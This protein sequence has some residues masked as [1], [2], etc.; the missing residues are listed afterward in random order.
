[1]IHH[2][3]CLFG[4]LAANQVSADPIAHTLAEVVVAESADEEHYSQG[5]T[6]AARKPAGLLSTPCSVGVVN[7]VL[8]RD[9]LAYR[10]EDLAPF[11]SGVQASSADSGFNT[12]LRI[13][14]FTTA[15]GAYLDGVLDN[16]RFQV[17]DMALIER[18]EILTGH[19]SVLYG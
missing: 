8:L 3:L 5:A 16:Q 15:G 6:G 13:R 17:R 4:L 11:V 1:M 7:Q 12:D 9:S 14:G 18:M 2:L 19:S 10:L